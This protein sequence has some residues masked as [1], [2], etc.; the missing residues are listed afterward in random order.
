MINN[1]LTLIGMFIAGA[2]FMW[3]R[4]LIFKRAKKTVITNLGLN[5]TIGNVY[6]KNGE[7]AFQAKKFF[8]GF[9]GLFNPVGWAKDIIGLLNIRKIALY[10]FIATIIAG[11][12]YWKGQQNVPITMDIGYGKEAHIDLNGEYLHI[13]KEGNV[14]LKDTKTNKIIKQISVKDVPGLKRKLAPFGF[15]FTPIA[16]IGMGLGDDGIEG[17]GGIGLSWLRYYKYRIQSFITNR[18]L[19]SLGLGYK[20]TDNAGLTLGVG[21]GWEGDERVSLFFHFEF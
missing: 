7:E 15:Q 6:K 3:L 19:Y 10:I 20:L 16:L 1:I 2:I 14:Y 18:G 8:A 5:A 12:F 21:K 9:G 4:P 13:D 17:E 11:F